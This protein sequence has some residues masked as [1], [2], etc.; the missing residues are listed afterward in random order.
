MIIRHFHNDKSESWIG[1]YSFFE[2]A[3]PNQNMKYKITIYEDNGL[4]ARIKIDGFSTMERITAKVWSHADEIRL[5]F[6][7]YYVDE[8]GKSSD[9]EKYEEGFML[10]EMRKE[11]GAIIT[12]W[13]LIQPLLIEN[14]K[15][16]Q[17][18]TRDVR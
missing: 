13:A 3:P 11:D 6:Y 18:F 10:L 5:T 14:R 16:G 1:N 12:D 15:A 17:Y 9:L 8:D 2:F 7:D 4:Y